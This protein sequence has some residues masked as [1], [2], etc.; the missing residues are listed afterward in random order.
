MRTLRFGR[1]D[2]DVA[3]IGFGTWPLGGP[4]G[5]GEN[6]VGWAGADDDASVDA[7]VRAHEVG[8]RHWDTADVYGNGRA[9]QV[10]GRAW[11]RVPRDEV[12]LAT[13]V[14]WD[15][16]EY[17][18][19]YHPELIRDHIERSL[20]NL[21][22]D[23]IDLF[24]LH[25]CDFGEN[26]VWLDGALEELHRARDAGKIRFV[27]LS[28]WDNGKV[29]RLFSRVDPDAV[30]VYRNVVDD[31]Y[32][33]SGLRECVEQADVG[34]VFFST[35]KHGLLLGKYEK[36]TTFG[37]GDVRGRIAAFKDADTLAQLRDAKDQ[38]VSRLGTAEQPVLEALISSILMDAPT[39]CSILGLRNPDQVTRA[40]QI[41]G[42][43][44]DD[45]VRFV[46]DLYAAIPTA[47]GLR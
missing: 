43:L 44:S 20:K 16:G 14:G 35:I 30:Q 47:G 1:T 29:A 3:A 17:E 18:H 28:D 41:A 32:A 23:R 5:E 25:H 37:E 34:V 7:L 36:P 11:S 19:F 40:G 38:V 39:A 4:N 45:D 46:R 33:S 42:E 12:F 26:D 24:Y 10:V 31:T 9:E 2:I 27:G 22:T 15:P 21:Q 6:S 13:K 8:I